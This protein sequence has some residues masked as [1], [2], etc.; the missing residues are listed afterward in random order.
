MRLNEMKINKKDEKNKKI[1]IKIK[2][3]KKKQNPTVTNIK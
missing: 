1:E 2:E 3:K